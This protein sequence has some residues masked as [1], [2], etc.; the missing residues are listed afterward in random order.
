M[1]VL[2]I[3]ALA[4]ALSVGSPA[5]ADKHKGGGGGHHAGSAQMQRGGGN[6]WH[7]GGQ[8]M[9]FGGDVRSGRSHGRVETHGWT[10]HDRVRVHDRFGHRNVVVRAGTSKFRDHYRVVHAKHRF[11][12][13]IYRRPHGWYRHHWRLG[14]RLPRAWFVRDYWI[15]DWRVY[16]LWAPYDGLVWVRVGEDAYLTD[17]YTGEVASIQY[18]VFW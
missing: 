2:Y 4:L 11:H 13:G 14:Q 9:R 15:P 10:A 7:G 5:L 3:G 17:P 18:G 6:K 8:R 12:A 16:G 1:K